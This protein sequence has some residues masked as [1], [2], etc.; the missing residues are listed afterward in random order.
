WEK[1]LFPGVVA[2]AIAGVALWRLWRGCLDDFPRA[3]VLAA[4]GILVAGAVLAL[5]PYPVMNGRV[6]PVP[7]PYLALYQLAP[8]F[9]SVRTPARFALMG[10]IG[11]AL[12]VAVGVT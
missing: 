12:L 4:L 3:R 2:L 1:R 5:G 11:L 7:L 6:L 8:G 10:L 9:Q